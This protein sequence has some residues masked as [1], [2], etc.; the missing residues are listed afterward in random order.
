MQVE[1]TNHY[2]RTV[3]KI[4]KK[5]YLRQ[6]IIDDT[7]S[8]LESDYKNEKLNFKKI[9]CKRDKKRHSIRVLGSSY[10]ILFSIIEDTAYLMCICSHD[11]Y[12]KFNK[13]C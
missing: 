7:I 4:L 12:D 2:K 6:S 9:V 11:D 8:L 3:T 10:R 13:K 1:F 5:H